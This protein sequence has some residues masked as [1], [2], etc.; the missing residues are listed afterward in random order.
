MFSILFYLCLHKM[1]FL[2]FNRLFFFRCSWVKTISINR[3]R[4]SIITISICVMYVYCICHATYI[5]LIHSFNSKIS[6]TKQTF[7]MTSMLIY[8][9]H[10][11][12]KVWYPWPNK[13]KC[14]ETDKIKM[15]DKNYY[16]HT[17]KIW[18]K[19]IISKVCTYIQ[20]YKT[21]KI[22]DENYFNGNV[23]FCFI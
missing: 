11:H 5:I 8:V 22:W 4:E 14:T 6:L 18:K 13:I 20:K 2:F 15:L 17:K 3:H 23:F 10:F 16:T 12:H 9:P 21:Y 1:N 7:I 19:F